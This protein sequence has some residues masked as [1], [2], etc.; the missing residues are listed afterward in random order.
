MNIVIVG[1]AYPLRG[2]IAIFDEL[3]CKELVEQGHNAQIVSYTLQYPT[4]LFPGKT[5]Y[6]LESTPP[7]GLKITTLLNSIN[8]ITWWQTAKFIINQKPDLV[9][10]RFWI[11]FMGPALG[12]IVRLL[13]QKKINIVSL[14]DNLIPHEKRIGDTI[15][16]KYFTKKITKF[17]VMSE[18]VEKD[19]HFI[20]KEAQTLLLRHP[21]YDTYGQKVPKPEA[22]RHL[23]INEND[24]VIL[25]FGLIR[26]YKGLDLLLEAIADIKIRNLNL[27]LIIAGEFYDNP[28]DYEKIIE[29][30]KL[31]DQVML[32]C[33]YIPN[34]EVKYYFSACDLVAL[35]YKTATQSGVTQIAFHFEKPVL[36]TNVGGL[37]E[38]IPH[39]KAGYVVNAVPSEI[40]EAILD[41]YENDREETFTQ[42][43]KEE[44]VKYSW[45][46]FV[47]KFLAFANGNYN[48]N[49]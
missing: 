42:G 20:K 38:I 32:H 29:R 10:V 23:K 48:G 39:K 47:S 8:P 28:D 22:K 7:T 33:H 44:K 5:Q 14:V 41:F 15:L 9:I 36:V 18:E 11:P 4:L 31:S 27:K 35:P 46:N 6:D 37:A 13:N 24:R 30:L 34:D 45:K 16:T 25:F 17:V 3:L 43:M 26:K 49:K 40:T 12:T 1:P 19:V 2:G 21:I